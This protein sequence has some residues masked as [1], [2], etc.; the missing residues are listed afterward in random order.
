MTADKT[1]RTNCGTQLA[2]LATEL[3]AKQFYWLVFDD[4]AGTGTGSSQ[5]PN[6]SNG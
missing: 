1:I 2:A 5:L 3:K 6:Q 4:L